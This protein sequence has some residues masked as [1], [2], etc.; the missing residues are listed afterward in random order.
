VV[1]FEL[2]ENSG[3]R[4]VI[5]ANYAELES[6]FSPS[7]LEQLDTV[8]EY[9]KLSNATPAVAGAILSAFESNEEGASVAG[10]VPSDPYRAY[11]PSYD[12]SGYLG[13][14]QPKAAQGILFYDL[15]AL[16][17]AP[18]GDG[19]EGGSSGLADAT[20]V[21]AASAADATVTEGAEGG[22]AGDA[23]STAESPAAYALGYLHYFHGVNPL[24]LVY[25]T[26]MNSYGATKSLTVMFSAWFTA[27]PPP[28]F[29]VAGPNPL[30]NW[31]A[32]CTVPTTS[33]NA[34]GGAGGPFQY[35]CGSSP[36]APPFGQPDQKSYLDF[37]TN[38]PLDSWQV[39]EANDAYMAQYIRLVS[40]FSQ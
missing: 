16:Q 39:S 15:L 29:V 30:Y 26:N 28:G 34:C 17:G 31:D 27:T 1:L 33:G 20:T 38:W 32:C 35:L 24:A 4:A 7:R 6:S 12:F 3:Y 5:D 10:M 18:S 36:P 9:A 11:I 22:A 14:N 8:L 40:K 13:S 23:G 2:T 25:L 21:D 19:G 37:N